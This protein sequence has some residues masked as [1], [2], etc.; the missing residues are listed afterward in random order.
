MLLSN[1]LDTNREG[2]GG[3]YLLPWWGL[4]GDFGTTEGLLCIKFKL[5]S[6]L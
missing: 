4:F 1:V 5:T 6:K 2:V 3:G